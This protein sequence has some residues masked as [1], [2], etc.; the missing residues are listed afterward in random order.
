MLQKLKITLKRLYSF[1]CQALVQVLVL[2]TSVPI[3]YILSC[4]GMECIYYILSLSLNI[5]NQNIPSLAELFL[6]CYVIATSGH[7]WGNSFVS[8]TLLYSDVEKQT[9]TYFKQNT[10][11]T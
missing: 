10:N 6:C 8:E 9:I 4:I 1:F 11:K 7:S 3:L 5:N 2:C